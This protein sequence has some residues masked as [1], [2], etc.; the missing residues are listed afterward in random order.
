MKTRQ[1]FISRIFLAIY[2]LIVLH[3]IVPHGHHEHEKDECVAHFANNDHRHTHG[4]HLHEHH[5]HNH[6]FLE[7]LLEAHAHSSQCD[8][9]ISQIHFKNHPLVKDLPFIQTS[10]DF[11]F[12]QQTIL[13]EKEQETLYSTRIFENRFLINNS[14]RAPPS[15][16]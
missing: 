11:H 7:A 4:S 3:N 5:H 8:E 12:N 6:N 9:L 14:L 2:A 10:V 13:L 15:L 16:G 1:R